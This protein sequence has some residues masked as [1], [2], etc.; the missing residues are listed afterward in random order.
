MTFAF[1]PA[2][3]ESVPLLI[4]VAGGT[5]SGKTMSALRLATGMAGGARFGVI[6]TESGRAKH[7][8]D[9][10]Q[11]DHGDLS[12]PFRPERYLEAILAAEEAHYPVVVVDSMSHEHAGE[13]GLLDWHEDELERMAGSDYAKRERVAMSAWI[14]PK[15]SH[16]Q[17]VARL[18][19]L[20][21][22]LILCFR[23]EEKLDIVKNRETGKTE[24]VPKT[25][26]VG[27]NGWL[28]ISEK[29][30][31]FE[32]TASFLLT[33]DQPG[34]PKPI[35]LQ[36]QHRAFIDLAKPL[37]EDVGRSLA[38]WAAGKSVQLDIGEHVKALQTSSDMTSL[39]RVFENAWRSL[40]RGS[41]ARTECKRI[42]EERKKSI[43]IT[44]DA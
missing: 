14:K 37:D 29:S 1:K 30:L 43:S 38:E 35:K 18:L 33:A 19:Q 36:S 2:V 27:L 23:A 17:M 10:F 20:R 9:Q 26:L 3:R 32:L 8:G 42:Y 39:E 31:P 41:D 6:D 24:I 4:G 13:G 7:Y 25:S 21:C 5:G 22:H 44:R 34:I 11:F 16:K 15:R 40:P 12:A 28:P